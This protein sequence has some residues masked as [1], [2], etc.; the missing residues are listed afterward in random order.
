METTIL[1]PHDT[2]PEATPAAPIEG[3]EVS[4]PSPPKE[5]E[6]PATPETPVAATPTAPAPPEPTFEVDGEKL[7]ASQ[8]RELREKYQRDSKWIQTNESRAAEL[9]R[10]EEELR[11]IRAIKPLLEQR[12]DIVQQL[13][14]PTPQRNFDA[15]MQQLY[16]QEPDRFQDPQGYVAWKMREAQVVS[17]RT[18]ALLQNQNRQEYE[19]RQAFEHNTQTEQYGKEKYLNN[20]IV[21]PAEFSRMNAWIVENVRSNNGRYSK[22]AYDVA[23]KTLFEDKFVE[24]VKLNAVKQAIAPLKNEKPQNSAVGIKPQEVQTTPDEEEDQ[25]L[26]K[27]VRALNPKYKRLEMQ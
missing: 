5:G 13:F 26:V 7:T 11:Q 2:P 24:N 27:R 4:P 19:Q 9:N 3:Q 6:Q 20:K 14:Q 12:P 22:E 21:T 17:D 25:A 8:I 18:A 16:A 1:E 15:E 23:F 10:Q